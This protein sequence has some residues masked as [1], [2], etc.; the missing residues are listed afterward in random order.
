V[1]YYLWF[2]PILTQ[3]PPFRMIAEGRQQLDTLSREPI[4]AAWSLSDKK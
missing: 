4:I 2:E 1:T 3:S